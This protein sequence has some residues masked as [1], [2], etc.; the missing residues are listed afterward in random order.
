MPLKMQFNTMKI[1]SY[2][3]KKTSFPL[4]AVLVF[5]LVAGAPLL[6]GANGGCGTDSDTAGSNSTPKVAAIS[7]FHFNPFDEPG[8]FEALRDAEPEEWESIVESSSQRGLPDFYEETNHPLLEAAL[9]SARSAAS[10][11]VYVVFPGD[12]LTHHFDD[13]YF[14]AAGFRDGLGLKRFI[15]KTVKYFILQVDERFPSA[16]VLFTLGNNDSYGGNY[17]LEAGGDFLADT[18]QFFLSHFLEGVVDRDE[19][20]RTYKAGGYYAADFGREDLVFL[21]L[22]SVLFSKRRPPPGLPGSDPGFI[23]LDWLEEQLDKAGSQDRQAVIVTH[24]PPGADAFGTTRAH[25]APDGTASDMYPMWIPSYQDRFLEIVDEYRETLRAFYFGHTHM[26]EFRLLF[27]DAHTGAGV[28]L[29]SV[30]AVSPVFGNNPAYKVFLLGE[31][32]WRF[33]DYRAYALDLDARQKGFQSFY[34]FKD[35]YGMGPPSA[36]SLTRLYGL[37]FGGSDHLDL[38]LDRYYSGSTNSP[39][40]AVNRNIYRCAAGRV[41]DDGFV[42]C[43]NQDVP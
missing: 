6:L 31:R 37:F 4:S 3:M 39:I 36:A 14:D 35:V 18:A 19:F 25:M 15:L 42:D 34:S 29:V 1:Q 9:D 30:P 8:L 22:N 26:D 17:D 24:I 12:I 27:N 10:G 11:A 32:T 7:D 13:L 33:D 23:Q 41:R 28:P 21:S 43:V 40:N 20:L 38:Y 2:T 5:L 16:P